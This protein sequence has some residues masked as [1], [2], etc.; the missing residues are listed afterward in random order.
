MKQTLQ[1]Q[2]VNLSLQPQLS[3]FIYLI[4]FHFEIGNFIFEILVQMRLKNQ[5]QLNQRVLKLNLDYM[6]HKLK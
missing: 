1:I 6:D 4:D 3:Q 2:P 5:I